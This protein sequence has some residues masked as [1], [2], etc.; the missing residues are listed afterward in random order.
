MYDT[1][2]KYMPIRVLVASSGGCGWVCLSESIPLNFRIPSVGEH[3]LA[4]WPFDDNMSPQQQ[5]LGFQHPQNAKLLNEM[6]MG[7]LV[8]EHDC[9]QSEIGNGIFL[10]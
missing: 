1:L 8:D 3:L 7:E 4:T 9:G 6:Q 2:S 10:F 5:M